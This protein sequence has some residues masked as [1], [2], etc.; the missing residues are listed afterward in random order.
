MAGRSWQV[1]DIDWNRKR[2]YV[3]ASDIV[4]SAQ[5]FSP[6]RPQSFA[7]TDAMRR[8]AVGTD[9]QGVT[10]SDRA[11][12][13]LALVRTSHER[14]VESDSTVLVAR[15]ARHHTWWTWAGG[16]GNLTLASALDAVDPGLVAEEGRTS[17]FSLRIAAD[18]GSG[19]LR[20]ALRALR[21]TKLES[22][23]IA[24]DPGAIRGLKFGDLLP[25]HL[26]IDTVSRR[27]LDR[28]STGLVVGKP[29]VD[30][31]TD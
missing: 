26:A 1:R 4:G 13:A 6:A 24:V 10:M 3:E 7:L 2:L 22:V 18:A 11:R 28:E 30:R 29:I 21:S 16:R 20:S 8:I 12:R 27:M 23:V 17:D 19:R 15:D 9:P 25:K 31:T 14:N 5:W